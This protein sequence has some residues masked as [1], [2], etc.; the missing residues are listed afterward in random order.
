MK[1]K[2]ISKSI[3]TA[4]MLFSLLLV[5]SIFSVTGTTLIS[6]TEISAK[7]QVSTIDDVIKN[8]KWIE[9]EKEAAVIDF[10]SKGLLS[11]ESKATYLMNKYDGAVATTRKGGVSQRIQNGGWECLLQNK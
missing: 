4:A 5:T 3:K 6:A 7:E 1:I 10:Q 11:S 9:M 2:R 8:D